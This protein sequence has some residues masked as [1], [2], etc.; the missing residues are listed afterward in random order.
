LADAHRFGFDSRDEC[1]AYRDQLL[2]RMQAAFDASVVCL[3][4]AWRQTLH[5]RLRHNA[6]I[7]GG[8]AAG[9]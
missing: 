5:E 2:V 9:K 4:E 6:A 1:G 8:E 3:D 7:L